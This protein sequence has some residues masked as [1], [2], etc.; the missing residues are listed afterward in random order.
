[1]FL[2]RIFILFRRQAPPRK[3]HFTHRSKEKTTTKKT[4]TKQHDKKIKNITSVAGGAFG[5]EMLAM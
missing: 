4:Q 3:L 2:F 5:R 1:V